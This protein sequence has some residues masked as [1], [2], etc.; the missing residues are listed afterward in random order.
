MR[1]GHICVCLKEKGVYGAVCVGSAH[2]V[3]VPGLGQPECLRWL[4][5]SQFGGGGRDVLRDLG[6]AQV[7]AVH[8][9]S[10]AAAL[11]RTHW[12]IAALR[13]QAGVLRAWEGQIGRKT[14]DSAYSTTLRLYS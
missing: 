3:A 4:V 14:S 7:G 12:V 1:T 9:I 2:W 11:G 13:V 6:E 5:F 8:H 10:L